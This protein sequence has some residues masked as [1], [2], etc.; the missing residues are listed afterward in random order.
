M[1][2]ETATT[3]VIEAAPHSSEAVQPLAD[4]AP[5]ALLSNPETWIVVAFVLF[6]AVF[7]R[8]LAPKIGQGLD[9][10]ADKIREQLEQASRLRAEAE[11]LL[12]SYQLAQEKLLKEA[13]SIIE[14]AKRDAVTLRVH[15]AEELK[16]ALDRRSQQAQEKIARAEAEAVGAI[17]TRIIETATER[18]RDI[19]AARGQSQSEAQTVDRALA[20]I[21][22]QVH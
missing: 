11:A 12:A 7:L 10:R 15:A 6:I 3:A 9:A 4:S 17:R 1:K 14:T 2:T 22:Q 19:L 8:Y 5:E 13:E 21:A 20:A 18:A 16:I